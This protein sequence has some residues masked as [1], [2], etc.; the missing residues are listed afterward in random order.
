MIIEHNNKWRGFASRGS[1]TREIKIGRRSVFL[2]Y[3]QGSSNTR[4]EFKRIIY[5]I[6]PLGFTTFNAQFLVT[7]FMTNFKINA[8]FQAISI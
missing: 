2:Y 5:F 4:K 7:R 6:Y 1:R 8:N 3:M